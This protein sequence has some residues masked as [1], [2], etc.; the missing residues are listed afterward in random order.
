[1]SVW[2]SAEKSLLELM[3]RFALPDGSCPHKIEVGG[4]KMDFAD[5][6][7]QSKACFWCGRHGLC[8][9]EWFRWSTPDGDTCIPVCASC[10]D[11]RA[12][13]QIVPEE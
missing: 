3:G 10:I 9:I 7:D 11:E 1:M 5:T 12:S 13:K 2:D 4:V 8:D 6:V